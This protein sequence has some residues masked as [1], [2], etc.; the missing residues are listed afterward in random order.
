MCVAVNVVLA[1]LLWDK[2]GLSGCDF[3]EWEST[4]CYHLLIDCDGAVRLMVESVIQR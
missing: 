2:P 1:Q 4:S 3:S